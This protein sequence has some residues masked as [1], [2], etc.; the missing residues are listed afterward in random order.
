MF[1][2]FLWQPYRAENAFLMATV[3]DLDKLGGENTSGM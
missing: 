1:T 3:F 2:A